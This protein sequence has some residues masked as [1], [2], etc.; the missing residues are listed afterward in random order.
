MKNQQ[1]KIEDLHE[2][3]TRAE[4]PH[5]L[6]ADLGEHYSLQ[7]AVTGDDPD[8][9]ALLFVAKMLLRL[10]KEDNLKMFAELADI[11]S[12]YG[13]REELDLLNRVAA[14]GLVARHP[15][16]VDRKEIN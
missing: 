7:S 16:P 12:R 3:L 6:I 15:R 11:F 4:T 9:V 13:T 5:L 10:A 2:Q 8:L 1:K 14:S